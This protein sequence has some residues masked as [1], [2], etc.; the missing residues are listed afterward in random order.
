MTGEGEWGCE[1]NLLKTG[2]QERGATGFQC[3]GEEARWSPALTSEDGDGQGG[4]GGGWCFELGGEVNVDCAQDR[5]L[6]ARTFYYINNSHTGCAGLA[7][8]LI[9]VAH[10]VPIGH[11][12]GNRA[13]RKNA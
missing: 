6:W 9:V 4:R 1:G 11:C 3:A 8:A 10:R 12:H 5:L 13:V 7:D 2:E